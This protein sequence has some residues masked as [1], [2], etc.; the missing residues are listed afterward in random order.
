MVYPTTRLPT[1]CWTKSARRRRTRRWKPPSPY[2]N[3]SKVFAAIPRSIPSGARIRPWQHH[4]WRDGQPAGVARQGKPA[5]EA[6]TKE[7]RRYPA[8]CRTTPSRSF[9]RD[10]G[11]AKTARSPDPHGRYRASQRQCGRLRLTRKRTAAGPPTTRGKCWPYHRILL[12]HFQPDYGPLSG[13]RSCG[14]APGMR[15]KASPQQS[16]SLLPN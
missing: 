4:G 9:P 3:P 12:E 5:G 8:A 16:R 1:S 6:G 10:Q 7:M 15:W 11:A 14:S 13:R 2:Q